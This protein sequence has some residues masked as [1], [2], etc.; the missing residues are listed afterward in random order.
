MD[1]NTNKEY[2]ERYYSEWLDKPISL[3]GTFGP[4]FTQENKEYIVKEM[5][6]KLGITEE[7]LKGEPNLIKLKLTEY[8]R[9]RNINMIL[10]E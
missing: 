3:V 7:E 8:F 2:H 1:Y 4:D 9:D 6:D 10:G 5:M